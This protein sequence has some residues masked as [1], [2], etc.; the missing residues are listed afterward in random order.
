MIFNNKMD[1][2]TIIKFVLLLIIVTIPFVDYKKYLMW[3][4]TLVVK[5]MMLMVIAATS[6]YNIE[7]AILMTI[8]FFLLLI[9]GNVQAIKKVEPFII[10]DFPQNDCGINPKKEDL[11]DYYVDDKLKPYENYIKQIGL[12]MQQQV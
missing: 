4:D 7:V 8:L 1:S 9:N 6:F 10:T 2:L 3:F 12:P 11:I 5:I